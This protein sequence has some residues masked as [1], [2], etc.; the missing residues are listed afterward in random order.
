METSQEDIAALTRAI[1]G[2]A[3]A[4]QEVLAAHHA[5]LLAYVTKHFPA[6]VR[7]IVDPQDIVQDT[8]FEACRLIGKFRPDG[9][10]STFRWLITI[11]RHRMVHLLRIQRSRQGKGDEGC[12]GDAPIV[13]A[14]SEL[15]LYRRTP[16]RSAASHEFLAA[17][18]QS[19]AR[20][21]PAYRQV[22]TLRHL[23][24]LSVE[25]TAVR[26]NRTPDAV[27]WLCSRALQA[28]RLDL[29]SASFFL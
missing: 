5:Q 10:D 17:V 4:L 22:V 20:L 1:A 28:I 26:M 9:E 16:S 18:E 14:L 25:E 11:A 21:P 8:C 29:R 6:E 15:A 27:Y 12:Q 24:G 3:E 23:E 13:A 19:I 2:D 7:N